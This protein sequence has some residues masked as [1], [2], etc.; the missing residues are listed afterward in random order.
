[1]SGNLTNTTSSETGFNKTCFASTIP[2]PN[3]LI[4]L[5]IGNITKKS[6]GGRA[7][8][9]ADPTLLTAVV[10]EFADLN[11][12]LDTAE[13]YIGVPYIWGTYNMIVLPAPFP[14]SGM[15]NPMLAY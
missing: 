14:F 6:L 7:N 1:M 3:Y 4:A 15:A 12:W 13:A 5:T 10:Q 9:Y 11:T 8:L 2:V